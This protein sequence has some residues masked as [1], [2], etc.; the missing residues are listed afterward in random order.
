M[1]FCRLQNF[2][3]GIYHKNLARSITV[4]ILDNNIWGPRRLSAKWPGIFLQH[5]YHKRLASV[6]WLNQLSLKISSFFFLR[7]TA[8]SVAM[9]NDCIATYDWLMIALLDNRYV[10]SFSLPRLINFKLISDSRTLVGL[11]I[12]DLDKNEDPWATI[13]PRNTDS[14]SQTLLI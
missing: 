3:W 9:R 11:K 7:L 1:I 13:I 6:C 2:F 10:Y 4:C 14:R 8:L 5:S 12:G